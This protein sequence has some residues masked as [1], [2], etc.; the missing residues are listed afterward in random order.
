MK[1]V[2]EVKVVHQGKLECLANVD[3]KETQEKG[4]CQGRED[5]KEVLESEAHQD[6]LDHRVPQVLQ[7][8]K[9]CKE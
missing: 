8:F 6:P 5:C 7:E 3:P 2:K 4:G 1:L 9:V